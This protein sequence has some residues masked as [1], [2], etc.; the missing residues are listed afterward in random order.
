VLEAVRWRKQGGVGPGSSAPASRHCS[1]RSSAKRTAVPTF[2]HEDVRAGGPWLSERAASREQILG[3][4]SR[5]PGVYV[6]RFYDCIHNPDGTIASIRPNRTGVPGTVSKTNYDVRDDLGSVRPVVP[7]LRVVH[8]RFTIE[9]KRGCMVGCRFCQAGMISRPLRERDPRQVIEIARKGIR[10][11][12]YEEISL[13]SLSSADYSRILELTR[14]LRNEFAGEGVSVSLPSL[15]INAFDVDLA[16]E[17]GS[18]RKSGFTFAP[19]A[20]T[21]RLRQVI[22]KAVDEQRFL[23]TLETVLSK[24]WRTIKFYFMCGLPT[25]TDED[26]QGIVDL[27][28]KAIELG[29]RH[30]GRKFQLN[31]SLSPFIPKPQTPFQW[32]GQPTI[33]EFDRKFAYVESRI[34]RRVVSLKKHSVRESIIEGVLSRGDRRVG[35]GILRAWQLGCRFDNW[36]EHL[37]FDLWTQAFEESGIDPGF[38]ASRQRLQQEILPWDHVDAS[39]GR[40]FLW[41][42][43]LRSENAAT[44]AD[45]STARCAGC[46]ACDFKEVKNLLAVREDGEFVA[47]PTSETKPRNVEPVTRIRLTFTKT[48]SLR[49]ISHLDLVKVVTLILRRSGL[50]VAYSQGFNPQVRLQFAPP[51]SLGF[52]SQGEL[53]DVLLTEP[54]TPDETIAK[55]RAILLD[56]LSWLNAEELPLRSPAL[57]ATVVAADY[58]V[59][60]PD[61]TAKP[62]PGH[63]G[64]RI[65][66]FIAS[67]T[68][69]ATIQVKE[70]RV[71]KDLRKAVKRLDWTREDGQSVFQM[72][73]SLKDGEY[74]NPV[75]ALEMILGFSVRDSCRVTRTRLYTA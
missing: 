29:R 62:E 58:T 12:G 27:T 60:F 48:G 65:A 18:V 39:L 59:S 43:K 56:G 11:T 75:T 38:Y 25:E 69:P 72:T 32:H 1:D 3:A 74:V 20:G 71:T 45:C 50:P 47:P 64:D 7:L 6:P 22:N 73:L 19:E 33:E 37:R 31:V 36:H 46:E 66:R 28:N 2:N 21:A 52:A 9:L 16:D 10:N 26:L 8:D 68:F 23:E 54:V 55:L 53:A 5:I 61:A 41:E 70:K 17:I 35:R 13:L 30:C 67:E 24:G 63:P 4:L 34:N 42:E 51:M 14:A 15:R 40:K 57:N 49:F 44:T